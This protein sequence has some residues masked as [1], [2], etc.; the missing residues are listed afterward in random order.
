MAAEPNEQETHSNR[1]SLAVS[2]VA[3]A[4]VSKAVVTKSAFFGILNALQNVTLAVVK[5]VLQWWFRTPAKLFRPSRVDPWAALNKFF[6]A[7]GISRGT[8]RKWW[9]EASLEAS[10][11]RAK[12]IT[13]VR[14]NIMPLILAN[15]ICGMV[16]F[17]GY[18]LSNYL[19]QPYFNAQYSNERLSPSGYWEFMRRSKNWEKVNPETRQ[20]FPLPKI[21]AHNFISGSIG[22]AAQG[23]LAAPWDVLRGRV[24]QLWSIEKSLWQCL[25]HAVRERA[26]G[27][28]PLSHSIARGLPF[29]CVKDALTFGMFFGAFESSKIFLKRAS[30]DA[31]GSGTDQHGTAYRTCN[32]M[33]TVFAGSFAGIAYQLTSFPINTVQHAMQ[34]TELLQFRLEHLDFEAAPQVDSQPKHTGGVG[35]SRPGYSLDFLQTVHRLV[36]QHGVGY[37]FRGVVPSLLRAIP[38]SSLGLL[39]FELLNNPADANFA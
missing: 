27:T 34:N 33:A 11:S 13:F 18:S 6:E 4:A 21:A 2:G 16:L 24:E 39:M 14:S 28:A 37:L 9:M 15:S 23:L 7:E 32:I 31:Y 12:G 5:P 8:F 30:Y 17:Q 38:P 10:N 19:L 35:A 25:V 22:G 20:Y 36:R 3:A 29:I 1:S 26:S